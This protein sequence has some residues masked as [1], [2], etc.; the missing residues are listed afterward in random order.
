MFIFYFVLR[1]NKKP[2]TLEKLEI[3]ERSVLGVRKAKSRPQERRDSG[4]LRSWRKK[5]DSYLFSNFDVKG[6]FKTFS[7]SRPKK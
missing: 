4:M 5:E 2:E 7:R 3:S 6:P 1:Y